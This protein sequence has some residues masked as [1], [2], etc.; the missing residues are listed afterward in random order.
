MTLLFQE[1]D[2]VLQLSTCL[3]HGTAWQTTSLLLVMEAGSV[4]TIVVTPNNSMA[5]ES[6]NESMSESEHASPH[7]CAHGHRLWPLLLSFFCVVL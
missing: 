3:V 5:R 1:L 6:E 7:D 2:A 4:S